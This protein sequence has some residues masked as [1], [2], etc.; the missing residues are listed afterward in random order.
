MSESKRK[1]PLVLGAAI[2]GV[3]AGAF[4]LTRCNG[5]TDASH[6]AGQNGCNG[7]NGCGAKGEKQKGD[8]NSCSGPNGC[9]G[10]GTKGL[11]KAR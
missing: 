7:P 3:L 10:H 2:A 4:L 9:D 5:S 11:V 1:S 6:K 8:Q